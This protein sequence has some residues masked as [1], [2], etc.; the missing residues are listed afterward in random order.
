MRYRAVVG[1][2]LR[3]EAVWVP[4][5]STIQ[6]GRGARAL[7]GT[8]IAGGAT[9]S[10]SA[11]LL[12][13]TVGAVSPCAA[14]DLLPKEL[15]EPVERYMELRAWLEPRP[16]PW[17]VLRPLDV[18]SL[19]L[20]HFQYDVDRPP[21]ELRGMDITHYATHYAVSHPKVKTLRRT[22]SRYE[23]LELRGGELTLDLQRSLK[24]FW[25]GGGRIVT[26]YT[27][28]SK[29]H[30]GLFTINLGRIFKRS[31]GRKDAPD[32]PTLTFPNSDAGSTN[33][34]LLYSRSSPPR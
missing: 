16:E 24:F 3:T 29:P 14:A 17:D 13:F 19:R 2:R 27:N 10:L 26:L 12:G 21:E 6:G 9:A 25:R 30:K 33:Q 28:P 18:D 8:R 7:A 32:A 1:S 4:A 5:E 23:K 11:Y 31:F 15:R 20:P 34:R 22:L